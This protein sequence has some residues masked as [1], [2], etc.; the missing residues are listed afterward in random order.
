[1]QAT[2]G[3]LYGTTA[4]GGENNGGVLFS[5]NTETKQFAKLTDF[6]DTCGHN[7]MYGALVQIPMNVGTS[8]SLSFNYKIF[9]VCQNPVVDDFILL[10][11]LNKANQISVFDL[12][13]RKVYSQN[14]SSV[15]HQIPVEGLMDGVYL[16]KVEDHKNSVQIKKILLKRRR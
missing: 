4:N 16:I 14:T 8:E 13:G 6:S 9:D 3:L 1:M 2:D 10:K 5:L 7:P 12:L 15:Y 11:D